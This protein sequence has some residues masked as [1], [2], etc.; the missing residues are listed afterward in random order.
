MYRWKLSGKISAK[1]VFFGILRW[2]TRGSICFDPRRNFLDAGTSWVGT[3]KELFV[4]PALRPAGASYT[5]GYVDVR[6]LRLH[7]LDY[8]GNGETVVALHGLLQNA[9]AFDA[10]APVLVPHVHLIALNLPGRGDSEW[11]PASRYCLPQYMLDLRSFLTKLGA[12]QYAL[13]GT[14]LGGWMARTYAIAHPERV[15]RL[16]LNDCASSADVYAVYRTVKRMAE[17]PREFPTIRAAV[18]WFLA[19][20]SLD[21]LK[22]DALVAWVGHYLT[23][24]GTGR[25]RFACDP[26]VLRLA[27]SRITRRASSID[28]LQQPLAGVPLEQARRLTMPVLILRGA[29]SEVISRLAVTRFLRILPKAESVEVPG[30]GHSPTLY[31]PAAQEALRAFFGLTPAN[32]ED[33][34]LR[35]PSFDGPRSLVTDGA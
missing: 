12:P 23:Q 13:I 35:L 4:T 22:R 21:H 31:E 26:L 20:R 24:T 34:R 14:S 9:H 5:D 33:L 17:A 16:V 1:I 18:N 28:S 30:A 11:A 19:E 2:V 7:Y 29:R 10:I 6:G 32:P 15:F 3:A 27:M 8:G 25:L